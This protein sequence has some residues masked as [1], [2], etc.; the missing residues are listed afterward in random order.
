MVGELKTVT[1]YGVCLARAGL[2]LVCKR[3]GS[4]FRLRAIHATFALGCI[5]LLLVRCYTAADDEAPAAGQPNGVSILRDYG[6]V[7]YLVGDDTKKE[8]LHE[9]EVAEAGSYLKVYADNQDFF[10]HAVDVQIMIET[11]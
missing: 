10:D 3:I 1:F 5:N 4:P 6:Q 9:V 2:T 8:V 7:D 11:Y